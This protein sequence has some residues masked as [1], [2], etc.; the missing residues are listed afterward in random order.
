MVDGRRKH[1][2]IYYQL[3]RSRIIPDNSYNNIRTSKPSFERGFGHLKLE[4]RNL[5]LNLNH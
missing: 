4:T 3:R 5:R 1:E 2:A